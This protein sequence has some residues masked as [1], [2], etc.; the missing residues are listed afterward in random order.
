MFQYFFL[1]GLCPKKVSAPKAKSLHLEMC[2]QNEEE[3]TLEKKR[4][5]NFVWMKWQALENVPKVS[6]LLIMMGFLFLFKALES[7]LF[8]APIY[9]HELPE[10]DFLII[11]TSSGYVDMLHFVTESIWKVGN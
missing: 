5:L 8:R 9:Q 7:N 4:E 6:V 1:L 2:Y 11:R 10:T 3:L